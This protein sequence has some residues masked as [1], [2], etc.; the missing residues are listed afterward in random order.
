MESCAACGKANISL[1][2]CKACKLVK[3]CGVECQ[4]AH[5]RMHKKSCRIKAAELFDAK[6]FAQ[7]PAREDCHICMRMLPLEINGC[8][9]HSCCGKIICNGC[10]FSLTRN[11][12]PFC[13]TPEPTTD[14]ECKK[15]LFERI[16]KCDD[17]HAILIVGNSYNL[18]HYGFPVDHTKA[19]EL[20]ERSSKLGS[21]EGHYSLGGAY[22]V[23]RGVDQDMKKAI[24]HFQMAA[25][26]GHVLARYNVGYI[27]NADG[28]HVRA[29]K[30][31]MIAAKY[32][33]DE[34]M[35]T[36]KL[37]FNMNI[38][39]ITKEDFENT[40]RC[41]QASQDEMRS[42]ERDRAQAAWVQG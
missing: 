15:R 38:G 22:R 23:G 3:Y 20:Y 29:V 17:P 35:E 16:E 26:M 14:D 30:H 37:G 13:N 4:V 11:C 1:K 39:I 8:G 28:N 32:G 2:S 25:M 5:R 18:G 42:E 6:L 12:C 21:A 36:L 24:H 31:F 10:V 7:P 40:L 9:Y 19:V 27:E 33:H 41:Y 34:S